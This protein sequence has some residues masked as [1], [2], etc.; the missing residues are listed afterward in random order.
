MTTECYCCGMTTHTDSTGRTIK[1]GDIIVVKGSK[2]ER[3]VVTLITPSANSPQGGKD[4]RAERVDGG[5]VAWS[6]WSH[7]SRVTV[8]SS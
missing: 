4:V 7:S 5:N 3:K 6:T 2:I 1:L 8:V